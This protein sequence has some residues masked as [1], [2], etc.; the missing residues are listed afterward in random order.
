MQVLDDGTRVVQNPQ[1]DPVDDKTK[2]AAQKTAGITLPDWVARPAPVPESPPRPLTPSKPE[3]T[4]G[5]DPAVLSPLFGDMTYRYKRGRLIHTLF[6]FL[7]DLPPAARAGRAARWLAEPAHGLDAD[8]QAEMGA[9]VLDVLDNPAYA[10]LF[11]PDSRAEVPLT[12]LLSGAR[13][14]SGQID[15]LLVS[16]DAV[17][18]I[19]YKTNR[20]APKSAD[21]V[22][23]AYQAQMRSYRDL[24]QKIWPDRPVRCLLLWTDGPDLMDI[25][26]SI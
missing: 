2:P 24:L 10:P 14:V 18:V 1:T 5:G 21:A 6:Q 16:D 17:T 3:G 25:T 9:R 26:D 22:P 8:A 12:G 15:R 19:D 23:A 20:P 11:G 7:P 13:I 4:E